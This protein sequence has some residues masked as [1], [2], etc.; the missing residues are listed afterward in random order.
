MIFLNSLKHPLFLVIFSTFFTLSAC[1]ATEKT[2]S[3]KLNTKEKQNLEAFFND[4]EAFTQVYSQIKRLYVEDV[5]NKKLFT[6]A[7]KGMV[8]GLDPHSAYLEPKEQKTLLESASGKFGG[9]G[10]VISKKD[11]II[12]VI[13]PIDDTP[14]YKAGIQAGDKIVKINNKPVNGMSLEDGVKLMRGKPGTDIKITIVRKNT[15]P[16]VVKITREIITITSVKGYLLKDGIGYIRVSSFQNPTTDLLQKT[17]ERLVNE[18]KGDLKSLILDLRNNPGGVLDGAVD[19]SNLFLDDT[20]LIVSTKSRLKNN[21]TK[22]TADPGDV[23]NGAPMVVLINEGSASASEIVSGALQD[24]KRAIIMGNTSFGKG[25]VQTILE[26]KGGYG[27]KVT[28]A[29]YYTPNGR[30]IQAKGIVPDVKLKNISLGKEKKNAVTNTKESDLDGHLE[31]ED[32][33]ELS[34]KEILDAQ[35][36]KK[37]ELDKKA[38]ERLEKDYFVHEARNLL[39]ALAVLQK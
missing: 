2:E 37:T 6:N 11:N 12:Q 19:I 35:E 30:S 25:S 5:D 1:N 15:K 18:N 22:F 21:S 3:K 17:L 9:L 13:S 38:L 26:L 28:T 32:P 10:I 4:L 14:A 39:K 24:H 34:S 20:G 29:R 8:N 16:F 7:I 23:L 33:S 36:K 27:L 31:V